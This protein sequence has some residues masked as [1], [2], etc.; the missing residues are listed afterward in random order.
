MWWQQYKKELLSNRVEIALIAGAFI[1]WTLFLLSRVGL[2]QG[3]IIV[4]IYWM[5]ASFL[6]LW[7]LW[8]SVQQYRQEWRENTSYLML[9]LPVR[10][11]VITSAKLAVLFTAAV[12]F[13]L[14]ILA[15]G[16]LLLARTGV[17]ALYHASSLFEMIPGEWIVKITLLGWAL[18][19]GSV[20]VMGL[21]A[22][23]A[24]MFSRLFTRFRGLVMV[25]TLLLTSW[26]TGRAMDVGGKLLAWLPD[27]HIRFLD[28]FD[29][30]L[31]LRVYAIQSGPIV[32]Y[33]LVVLGLYALLNVILERAVEV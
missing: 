24:Y 21:V 5:P 10:A 27:F 3:E 32:M 19:V 7:A 16:W 15:G 17:L 23:L 31:G 26:L 25:W 8:T 20:V 30:V 22:Q 29:G 9:S 33:A 18:T 4:G 14:L 13:S 1:V 11:W 12:G 6:P 28:F 2:W